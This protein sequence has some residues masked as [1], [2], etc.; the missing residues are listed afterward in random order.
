MNPRAWVRRDQR[1]W[2]RLDM[3][4]TQ[5]EGELIISYYNPFISRSES[6]RDRMVEIEKL[7]TKV[8]LNYNSDLV[9]EIVHSHQPHMTNSRADCV[10][11][12]RMYEGLI[13]SHREVS[14]AI[15]RIITVKQPD[16]RTP[17]LS[18]ERVPALCLVIP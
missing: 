6:E 2:K 12:L 10:R 8:C 16:M 13:V 9:F 14:F 15:R 7:R 18:P 5:K 3:I 17:M 11:S 4:C 1:P